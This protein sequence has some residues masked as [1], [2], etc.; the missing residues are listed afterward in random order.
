MNLQW[1]L[2]PEHYST[3]FIAIKLYPKE[4]YVQYKEVAIFALHSPYTVTWTLATITQKNTNSLIVTSFINTQ[5]VHEDGGKIRRSPSHPL[6]IFDDNLREETKKRTIYCK[7]FA[8]DGSVTLDNLLEFFKQY[9]PYD[10][11]LVGSSAESKLT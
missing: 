2:L 1:L 10:T 3:F 8:K 9:G 4:W 11:V 5:Q 6:P 7:G